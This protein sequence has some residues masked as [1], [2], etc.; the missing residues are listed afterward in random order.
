[1]IRIKPSRCEFAL[2]ALTDANGH[3]MREIPVAPGTLP[4]GSFRAV[5]ENYELTTTAMRRTYSG[6]SRLPTESRMLHD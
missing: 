5:Q 3:A 1:V 2:I 4:N 6:L